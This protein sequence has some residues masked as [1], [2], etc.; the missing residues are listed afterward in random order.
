MGEHVQGCVTRLVRLIR[1]QKGD[2]RDAAA[3]TLA[4]SLSGLSRFARLGPKPRFS[5]LSAVTG[6][7]GKPGGG[8]VGVAASCKGGVCS[9]NASSVCIQLISR[10]SSAMAGD[11]ELARS[12]HGTCAFQV[13]STPR[14]H[15]GPYPFSLFLCT[16]RLILLSPSSSF[17]PS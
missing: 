6:G 7:D 2:G 9:G 14:C 12:R 15:S 17:S 5:L 3:G 13:L 8:V 1:L 16:F 11:R 10:L 4:E